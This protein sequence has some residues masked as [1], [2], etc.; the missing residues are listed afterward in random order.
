VVTHWRGAV[1][2]PEETIELVDDAAGC[3]AMCLPRDCTC[4]RGN[5]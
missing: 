3:L 1:S 5:Y 2:N 4:G